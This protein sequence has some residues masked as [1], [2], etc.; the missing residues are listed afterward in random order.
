MI[1]T[2]NE[3]RTLRT[4]TS[5]HVQHIG[6][7]RTYIRGYYN[8]PGLLRNQPD[9][10]LCGV[11]VPTKLRRKHFRNDFAVQIDGYY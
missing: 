6:Q 1:R 4:K 2:F 11:I 5:L 7:Y 9:R 8:S 3:L 10:S